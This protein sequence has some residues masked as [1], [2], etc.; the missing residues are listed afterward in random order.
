MPRPKKVRKI[1]FNPDVTYFK[2][3]G[4]PLS[5]LEEVDL[6]LEELEALRLADLKRTNQT[7]AAEQMGISQS[8]LHR[9]LAEG[10]RKIAEALVEGKAISVKGGDYKMVTLRQG[11]GRGGRG[12]GRGRMGGPYA[13]GPGGTC[14]CPSCGHTVAHKAGVPCPKVECPKCGTKMVRKN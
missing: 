3:R 10:R 13:A 7:E 4:V 8:T 1:R 14:E 6:S 11:S 12:G 2:P 9:V 5:E